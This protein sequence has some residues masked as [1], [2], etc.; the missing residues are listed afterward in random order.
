MVAI[1]QARLGSTRLQGKVLRLLSGKP[2]IEHIIKRIQAVS[3]I[4]RIVLATPSEKS[5]EPLE[6]IAA[7]MGVE[8]VSGPEEDVLE[9]FILAGNLCQAEHIVRVC[10]DNPL[11]DPTLMRSL[12]LQHSKENADYTFC[13]DPIPLG[14]GSEVAKLSALKQI[15][16]KTSQSAYREH[17]TTYFHD[18]PDAFHL[19]RV[20]TPPYLKGKNFRLTVDTEKD[21]QLIDQLYQKFYSPSQSPLNLEEILNFLTANP[22]LAS[23]NADVVQKN[24]REDLT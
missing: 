21:F 14:T 4:D 18:H 20:P 17:V 15:A 24:W 5:E 11:V 2:L 1:I 16:K 6:K 7:R 8:C 10:G 9:R 23:H 12:V 22:K 19:E 3:E 13:P